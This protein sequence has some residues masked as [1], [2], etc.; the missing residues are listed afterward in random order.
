M[1]S[2]DRLEY[3]GH[4][5]CFY[6]LR[7]IISQLIDIPLKQPEI[8]GVVRLCWNASTSNKQ[9]QFYSSLRLYETWVMADQYGPLGDSCAHDF[10][11]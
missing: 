10:Q 11:I 8:F 7:T 9:A 1:E 6:S 2:K 3:K 4:K 5:A